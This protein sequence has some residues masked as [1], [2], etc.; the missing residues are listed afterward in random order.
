LLKVT[1]F[2]WE[3]N[4]ISVGMQQKNNYEIGK[5]KQSKFGSQFFA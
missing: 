4:F 2:K 5:Q 3:E 1:N